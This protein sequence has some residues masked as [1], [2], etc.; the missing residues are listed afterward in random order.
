MNL[1]NEEFFQGFSWPVLTAFSQTLSRCRFERGD[2]LYNCPDAYQQWENAAKCIRYSIQVRSPAQGTVRATDDAGVFEENWKSE[3]VF[4]L[5]DFATKESRDVKTTQGKLFTLLWK[6]DWNVLNAEADPPVPLTCFNLSRRCE[7]I[8]SEVRKYFVTAHKMEKP[9]LWVMAY[10]PTHSVSCCKYETVKN[11]L[12]REFDVHEQMFTPDELGLGSV[13]IAPTV[14]FACFAIDLGASGRIADALKEVLYT[15][16][17]NKKTGQERF[18]LSAHG[19]FAPYHIPNFGDLVTISFAHG[20]CGKGLFYR[21]RLFKPRLPNVPGE[22]REYLISMMVDCPNHFFNIP[23]FCSKLKLTLPIALTRDR[24]HKLTFL[25]G[26]SFNGRRYKSE[27]ENVQMFFIE[28][29][30]ETI[31]VEVPVWA[32]KDELGS[33]SKIISPSGTLTGHIDLLRCT[34]DKIEIWDYKPAA[35]Q[36]ICAASQVFFY[37]VLLSK[38]TGI[39]LSKFQCGYF[40][41]SD[42]FIFNAEQAASSVLNGCR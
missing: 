33:Y 14:K 22:L 41:P 26:E 39:P 23:P 2:V 40:D 36:E 42:A 25:A 11:R 28:S 1:I 32:E 27:H 17:K 5:T 29:D 20:K 12:S 4:T 6:G 13:L 35:Y 10:D 15:P 31:A 38:R 34:N 21:Y 9:N 19:A 16:V 18:R 24:D 8:V 30:P 37:A 7:S 3:V